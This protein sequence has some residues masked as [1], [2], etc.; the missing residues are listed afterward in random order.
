MSQGD[1]QF[2]CSF[3]FL[4]H[5]ANSALQAL[6]AKYEVS[7]LETRHA[8]VHDGWVTT[9][10]GHMISHAAQIRL[11]DVLVEMV[12]T[13]YE[14]AAKAYTRAV[15]S[16]EYKERDDYVEQQLLGYSL[17]RWTQLTRGLPMVQVDCD[18]VAGTAARSNEQLLSDTLAAHI[19][20]KSLELE[21]NMWKAEAAPQSGEFAT[22]KLPSEPPANRPKAGG[23]HRVAKAATGEDSFLRFLDPDHL[24]QMGERFP[25]LASVLPGIA[26][27]ASFVRDMEA[28]KAK[29]EI[30]FRQHEAAEKW[31]NWDLDREDIDTQVDR[32]GDFGTTYPWHAAGC[33]YVWEMAST[34]MRSAFGDYAPDKFESMVQ[35]VIDVYSEK[36]YEEKLKSYEKA[37]WITYERSKA[38]FQECARSRLD[39][40]VRAECLKRWQKRSAAMAPDPE[41]TVRK[42]GSSGESRFS[43]ELL[44]PEQ[45]SVSYP[46]KTPPPDTNVHDAREKS[47]RSSAL[48]AYLEGIMAGTSK[49]PKRPA[50]GHLSEAAFLRIEAAVLEIEVK[51]RD[52]ILAQFTTMLPSHEHAETYEQALD[53]DD[54]TLA[55][56]LTT[57]IVRESVGL[58]IFDVVAQECLEIAPHK[59]MP[60]CLE[61]AAQF[62]LSHIPADESFI[63]D[64]RQKN[65]K[66]YIAKSLRHAADNTGQRQGET[67]GAKPDDAQKGEAGEGADRPKRPNPENP[68]TANRPECAA[69]IREHAKGAMDRPAQTN[70]VWKLPVT[71][72]GPIP[73]TRLSGKVDW[74]NSSPTI[75]HDGSALTP[76]YEKH[77]AEVNV[78][79][80]SNLRA[81]VEAVF[82]GPAWPNNSALLAPF[83]AYATKIF[84]VNA[85][86]FCEV[87]S[88][89]E[90]AEEVLAAMVRNLLGDVF[91]SEWESSPGEQVTRTDWQHGSEGWKGREFIVIAGNDPDP[92]CL[93]HDVVGDAITYR[94]RFH[95]IPPPPVPGEPPGINLSNQEWW[96]YIGLNERH[97]LAMAIKPYL[98]DR[99]AHWLL[100]VNRSARVASKNSSGKVNTDPLRQWVELQAEAIF[101]QTSES[102]ELSAAE[103]EPTDSDSFKSSSEHLDRS[104]VRSATTEQDS[105]H[106]R[107]KAADRHHTDA[108]R[109]ALVIGTAGLPDSRP[110]AGAVSDDPA[111]VE[112]IKENPKAAPWIN[113]IT[114]VGRARAEAEVAFREREIAEHWGTWS[115]VHPWNDKPDLVTT[116]CPWWVAG[117]DFVF[118]LT[119]E[120]RTHSPS[121]PDKT[122]AIL[123]QQVKM[124]ATW[125][126]W[127]RVFVHDCIPA[128]NSKAENLITNRNADRFADF[129]FLYCMRRFAESDLEEWR[130]YVVTL[131]GKPLELDRLSHVAVDRSRDQPA[132]PPGGDLAHASAA[133]PKQE[134]AERR[135]IKAGKGDATLLDGKRLVNFATAEQY[136]GISERQ[137]Q[138]LISSEALKTEGQGH[139]RKITVES[140]KAYL[141]P[142]IPN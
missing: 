73:I 133:T 91:G 116:D 44:Q 72:T 89:D 58:P 96:Q 99:V 120:W 9:E 54:D 37:L 4:S 103:S 10:A 115:G 130:K 26:G 17:R 8:I 114:Q 3:R 55:K 75:E 19:H 34:Y 134:Y 15:G 88:S 41:A 39:P 45:S 108:D 125:V 101:P 20:A 24:R 21:L 87:P 29:A 80:R 105:G 78:S 60:A 42:V 135:S 131:K 69:F 70:P 107:D 71:Q 76:E 36:V 106:T 28:A 56:W 23:P 66:L 2:G 98:E 1:E 121:T 12:E 52:M 111:I 59:D 13:L 67:D 18:P 46:D 139:N 119:F 136:L 74:I 11:V 5:E 122:E 118:R 141:P 49:A 31:G 86:A 51:A 61:A 104:E 100:V 123:P 57:S 30:A 110:P 68:A 33:E 16:S 65:F 90:S 79:E 128:P 138:K 97:N 63:P 22:G 25:E 94:Y 126:Y 132:E 102:E 50:I 92:N 43:T 48:V 82:G 62:A 109:R 83:R 124:F 95:A 38:E 53:S 127:K 14:S 64:L 140:L 7:L 47:S 81:E 113:Q 129:A 112:L 84:E 93:Y 32:F 35:L 137:R 117:A 40:L 142:E 77:I 6:R 27:A 85:R